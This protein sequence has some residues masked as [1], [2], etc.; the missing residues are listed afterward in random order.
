MRAITIVAVL[1]WAGVANADASDV[2]YGK[3]PAWVVPPP[4]IDPNPAP[5]APVHYEYVDRQLR[6]LPDREESFVQLRMRLLKPEALAFGDLTETWNPETDEFRVNTLKIHR[7]GQV[8]DVLRR[9][10]FTVLRR[11]NDLEYAMLD[12]DLTAA[13]QVEGLQVGD[14]LEYASTLSS[15]V[16]VRAGRSEAF[17]SFDG[18][19]SSGV[20]R[21]RVSRPKTEPVRWRVSK[22]LAG[23]AATE[24]DGQTVV[25]HTMSDPATVVLPR[26]APARFAY[27]RAIQFSEFQSWGDVSA[28]LAPHYAS[29]S[30]PGLKSP[31]PA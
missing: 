20:H 27:T 8:I 9:Q 2:L 21:V 1:A 6:L 31:L 25:E 13:L 11:E 16:P 5:G 15:R 29:A 30:K 3:P 10:R 24:V 7:N 28:L 4:A 22:D 26:G 14:V 23:V 19:S 18:E 12:G 17:A